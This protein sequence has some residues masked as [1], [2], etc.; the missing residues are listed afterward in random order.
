MSEG[1]HMDVYQR[2]EQRIYPNSQ[3]TRNTLDTFLLALVERWHGS[4]KTRVREWL[5]GQV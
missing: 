3:K 5:E 4:N 1:E 2:R